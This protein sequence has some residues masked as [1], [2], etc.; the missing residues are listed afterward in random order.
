MDRTEISNYSTEF[1]ESFKCRVSK[2]NRTTFVWNAEALVKSKMDNDLIVFFELKSSHGNEYKRV[3]TK[4]VEK[5]FDFLKASPHYYDNF[6]NYCN[7]P[8]K[9]EVPLEAVNILYLIDQS[10]LKYYIYI[11]VCRN[12]TFVRILCISQAVLKVF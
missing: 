3:L 9:L 4:V 12:F 5:P 11:F 8:K 1:F 2:F 7:V 6:A 10:S